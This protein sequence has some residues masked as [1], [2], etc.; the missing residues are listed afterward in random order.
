M[1][2]YVDTIIGNVAC[3]EATVLSSRICGVFGVTS[4]MSDGIASLIIWL[5]V[6]IG[7]LQFFLA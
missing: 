5:M 6:W 3:I 1:D 2:K 7:L 4:T